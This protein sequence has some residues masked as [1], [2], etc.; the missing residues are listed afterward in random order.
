[1]TQPSRRR[2]PAPFTAIVIA[3]FLVL[4][5]DLF[6]EVAVLAGSYRGFERFLPG[7]P[8]IVRLAAEFGLLLAG[9][10]WYYR[11]LG[12]TGARGWFAGLR[13]GLLTGLMAFGV[14]ALGLHALRAAAPGFLFAWWLGQAFA[15]SLAG[16]VL[17]A[18]LGGNPV[19]TVAAKVVAAVLLLLAAAAI[20]QVNG[21]VQPGET[22]HLS[23]IAP[24]V[25]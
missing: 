15:L 19:R 10:A 3:W 8:L 11:M 13:H 24:G 16:A 20:L 5:F 22:S 4:G 1:M 12:R 14:L 23:G 17:G 2:H 9:T 25:A 7:A 18:L 6:L 21:M